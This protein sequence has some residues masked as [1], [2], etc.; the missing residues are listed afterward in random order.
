[1]AYDPFDTRWLQ[2]GW[3][4]V[5]AP[6]VE[7]KTPATV[8]WYI[9]LTKWLI[10]IAAGVLVFG[11]DKMHLPELGRFTAF[12]FWCS[13]GLLALSIGTGIVACMQFLAYANR[14][15]TGQLAPG[16]TVADVD[17][18]RDQGTLLY[19]WCGG[20][21]WAGIAVFAIVWAA[22]QASASI[23]ESKPPP[24]IVTLPDRSGAL[25]VRPDAAGS[26][27]AVLSRAKGDQY[28]WELVRVPAASSAP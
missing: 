12:W 6:A 13:A 23:A 4:P 3:R 10:G 11:F 20:S 1:M 19:K 14:K 24:I 28:S 26:G 2:G 5:P 15:E 7:P 16:E 25:I 17:R 9:D 18:Y 8:G 22:S 27:A 21:L